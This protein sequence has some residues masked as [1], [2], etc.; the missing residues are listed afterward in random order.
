MDFEV[1]NRTIFILWGFALAAGWT[2]S[3]FLYDFMTPLS[4]IAFWTV[5]MSPPVIVS[6][7][8]MTQHD[9]SSLPAPWI[10]TAAVAVG[11]GFAVIEGHFSI[12]DIDNYAVFWFFLPAMAFAATTYYFEGMVS[13]M[14][15]TV[16]LINFIVAGSLLF[17]QGV[18]DQYFVLAGLTQALP[19]IYHGY[20]YEA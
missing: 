7:K 11:F 8:W 3:Y 2:V 16:A 15:T 18:M 20:I 5:L 13:K 14:Y 10:L 9:S 19:L 12:P 17:N 6:V 1:R 4:L